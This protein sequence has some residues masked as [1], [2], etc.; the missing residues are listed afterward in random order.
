VK[1]M[2]GADLVRD[3]IGS[4]VIAHEMRSY[5]CFYWRRSRLR[6]LPTPA[7]QPS[8]LKR[9]PN[10]FQQSAHL[11]G[12]LFN[13]VFLDQAHHGDRIHKGNGN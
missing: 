8:G 6:T 3:Y 5:R 12:Q 9:I 11:T 13:T 7:N 1:Q 4:A 10:A 2:V